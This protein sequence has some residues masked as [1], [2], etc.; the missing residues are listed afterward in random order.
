MP[1]SPTKF[2]RDRVA[3]LETN[4]DDVTGEIISR[5]VERL[6]EEGALD[7]TCTNFTGKKG[8]VGQTI[9]VSAKPRK[10]E[11]LAQV[12]VEETGTM[13]VKTAEYDRLIVPRNTN[14]IRFKLRNFDGQVSVKVARIAKSTRIKPE[15][16]QVREISENTGVPSRVVSDLIIEAAKKKLQ[17]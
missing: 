8:R 14:S 10:V 3:V 11:A 9:R 15:F 13:G 2:Q 16:S 4:V 12:L 6:L 5:A 7:V 1:R 17:L